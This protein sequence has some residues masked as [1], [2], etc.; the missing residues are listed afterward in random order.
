[1]TPRP[2]SPQQGPSSNIPRLQ[3]LARPTGGG[4]GGAGVT[5]PAANFASL[6][7]S[8]TSAMASLKRVGLEERREEQFLAGQAAAQDTPEGLTEKELVEQGII[9]KSASK[10]WRKG[11]YQIQGR[12]QADKFRQEVLDPWLRESTSGDVLA[13]DNNG[14]LPNRKDPLE[15]LSRLRQEYIT[16]LGMGSNVDFLAGYNTYAARDIE[17]AAEAY[18]VA[19]NNFEEERVSSFIVADSANSLEE[20]FESDGPVPTSE[21]IEGFREKIVSLIQETGV[22]LAQ[23]TSALI[24]ASIEQFA[25]EAAKDGDMDLDAVGAFVD[26]LLSTDGYNGTGN[27]S[28][29]PRY[30]DKVTKL[31]N[32]IDR[33]EDAA[34]QKK[35]RDRAERKNTLHAEAE[36]R[37][38]SGRYDAAGLFAL[39]A[40]LANATGEFEGVSKEDQEILLSYW[41]TLTNNVSNARTGQRSAR[42]REVE[43]YLTSRL[44]YLTEDQA[45]SIIEAQEGVDR[46]SLFNTVDR[47]YGSEDTELRLNVE[48]TMEDPAVNGAM[49]SVKTLFSSLPTGDRAVF[50]EQQGN[51]LSALR[52]EVQRAYSEQRDADVPGL[53]QRFQDEADNLSR[54]VSERRTEIDGELKNVRTLRDT[55]RFD[56][57]QEVLEGLTLTEDE[58]QREFAS[59]D[60][61]RGQEDGDHTIEG[62][63]VVSELYA[64]ARVVLPKAGGL[65][66]TLFGESQLDSAGLDPKRVQSALDSFG[67]TLQQ[68]AQEYRREN[69][70]KATGYSEY[71]EGLRSALTS[72]FNALIATYASPEE[73]ASIAASTRVEGSLAARLGD[74]STVQNLS[75]PGFEPYVPKPAVSTA[76]NKAKQISGE[77]QVQRD[78]QV[79][80]AVIEDIDPA[81]QE[82]PDMSFIEAVQA[83]EFFYLEQNQGS[84]AEALDF[85]LGTTGFSPQE[86]RDGAIT[87]G[88]PETVKERLRKS[89]QAVE[90][91]QPGVGTWSFRT[92]LPGYKAV[93]DGSSYFFFPSMEQMEAKRELLLR[94]YDNLL[95]SEPKTVPIDIRR[96]S[97]AVA[98]NPKSTLV[99]QT[100]GQIA[101]FESDP[102]HIYRKAFRIPGYSVNNFANR[103]RELLA[104]KTAEGYFQ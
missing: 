53:L 79:D 60:R 57:A 17:K 10:S 86:L 31:L 50:E 101:A 90:E 65:L 89:R 66:N 92:D 16:N 8:L 72:E 39:K 61:A 94:H 5:G 19:V 20:W 2:Q 95:S 80:G 98:S 1:M 35:Q 67:Q 74:I 15:E 43:D 77:T 62:N 85:R 40:D 9:P 69:R 71:R 54:R 46:A 70:S 91:F 26:T 73:Q 33:A 56:T 103:Q 51:L 83:N 78:F 30:S 45:R 41:S 48:R 63:G 3:P 87:V 7:E 88:I 64:R 32:A 25:Q 36:A 49:Q 59:L 55:G 38:G 6:S 18:T 104:Q 37:F 99:F 4:F 84:A 44:N 52:R 28:D 81:M 11:F 100:E 12:N 21:N 75:S 42:T 93:D 76:I 24:F 29:D 23:D 82:G 97:R 96:V 34:Y 14:V 47:L 13:G 102:N 58:R 27:F 22:P 68:R